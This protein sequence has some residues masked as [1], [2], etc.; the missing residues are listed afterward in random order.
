MA[1]V[2]F[3]QIIVA[4]I[5]EKYIVSSYQNFTWVAIIHDNITIH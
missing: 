3:I 4:K 2:E 5:V 1:W